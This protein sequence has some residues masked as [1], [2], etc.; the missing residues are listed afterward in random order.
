M[1][2]RATGVLIGLRI[3]AVGSAP[4]LFAARIVWLPTLACAKIHAC[5]GPLGLGGLVF[6]TPGPVERLSRD[7]AHIM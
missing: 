4:L 7:G 1:P 3:C 6:A 5:K 2:M